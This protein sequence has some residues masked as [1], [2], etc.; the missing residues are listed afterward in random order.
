MALPVASER[1]VRHHQTP[2]AT[3]RATAMIARKGPKLGWAVNPT[4]ARYR[5]LTITRSEMFSDSC[6][7]GNRSTTALNTKKM[8]SSGGMFRMIST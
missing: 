1:L 5:L 2:A 7:T 8:M 4:M 6:S 3:I